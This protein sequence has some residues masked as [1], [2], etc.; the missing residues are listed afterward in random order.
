MCTFRFFVVF[1]QNTIE[2]L[3]NKKISLFLAFFYLCSFCITPYTSG[4]RFNGQNQNL[5][6]SDSKINIADYLTK[7]NN[8]FTSFF[9]NVPKKD[10]SLH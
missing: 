2:S 5:I 9:P 6:L 8:N 3:V 4:N 7:N 10:L 1:Y